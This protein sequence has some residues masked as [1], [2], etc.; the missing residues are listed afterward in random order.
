MQFKVLSWNIW[1][2][3]FIDLPGVVKLLQKE[4]PDIIGLQE[5][6]ENGVNQAKQIADKLGLNLHDFRAF[7]TDRHKS[8]YSLGNSILAKFPITKKESIFLTDLSYYKQNWETEPRG[9]VKTSI[10]IKGKVLTILT[11]HL[12]YSKDFQPSEMRKKQLNTL[13]KHLTSKATILMGDFNSLPNSAEIKLIEKK[14]KNSDPKAKEKT[15]KARSRENP[16]VKL[17]PKYRIDYIFVSP[18][19]K[20]SDFKVIKDYSSDHFPIMATIQI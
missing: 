16:K 7:T 1:G 11:L 8:V 4:K 14:L 5:V 3:Y 6:K 19:I 13:L 2:G 15:W 18:D 20:V 10:N 12:A 9:L 17:N